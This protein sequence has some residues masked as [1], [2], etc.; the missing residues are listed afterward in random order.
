MSLKFHEKRP[1][2]S[3]RITRSLPS[4][5]GIGALFLPVHFSSFFS[6][7]SL[8]PSIMSVYADP[9][10]NLQLIKCSAPQDITRSP[11]LC[12][13][14]VFDPSCAQPASNLAQRT[15]PISTKHALAP[16]PQSSYG[17]ADRIRQNWPISPTASWDGVSRRQVSFFY[18]FVSFPTGNGHTDDA[19][20]F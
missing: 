17:T 15:P 4:M 12:D 3:L 7:S 20:D 10:V 19:A 8:H 9:P 18:L 14:R 11:L 1:K 2:E 6:L 16:L 13:V 5:A